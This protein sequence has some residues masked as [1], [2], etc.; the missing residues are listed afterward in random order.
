[1]SLSVTYQTGFL[2]ES[3]TTNV[4]NE[5]SFP[6]VDQQVL[7]QLRSPRERFVADQ[8]GMW[9]TSR[10]HSHVS[11]ERVFLCK[12]FTALRANDLLPFLV[13]RE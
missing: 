6:R 5:R 8:T 1:M 11:F 3:F 7:S 9:L 2:R 12:R 10:V 13:L 4:T